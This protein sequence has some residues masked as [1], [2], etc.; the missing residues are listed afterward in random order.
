MPIGRSA[1]AEAAARPGSFFVT[2]ETRDALNPI[3]RNG[4]THSI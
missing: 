2:T 3:F 1:I 4:L